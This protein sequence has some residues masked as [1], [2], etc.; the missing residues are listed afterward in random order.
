MRYAIIQAR[1]IKEKSMLE[2]DKKELG[3]R[4]AQSRNEKDWTQIELGNKLGYTDKAISKWES[5]E[6]STKIETLLKLAEVFDKPLEYFTPIIK[7]D[8]QAENKVKHEEINIA[9]EV[10][11]YKPLCVQH[12]ILI[13]DEVIK[14]KHISVIKEFLDNYPICYAEILYSWLEEN[15]LK[16]IYRFAVDYGVDSLAAVTVLNDKEKIRQRILRHFELHDPNPYYGS[17]DGPAPTPDEYKEMR[18]EWLKEHLAESSENTSYEQPTDYDEIIAH[19]QLN[20]KYYVYYGISH[21][22]QDSCNSKDGLDK[23]I[24]SLNDTKQDLLKVLGEMEEY[25]G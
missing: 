14:I 15:N 4:I 24:Q 3:N 25:N 7:T 6:C 16:N 9:E 11:K 21:N 8:E 13:L 1:N 10:E 23:H 17:E 20:G 12:G 22:N 5:G 2:I 18:K 19:Q